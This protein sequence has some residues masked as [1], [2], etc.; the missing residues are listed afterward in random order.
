LA[1]PIIRQMAEICFLVDDKVK[2]KVRV[3]IRDK[4]LERKAMEIPPKKPKTTGSNNSKN[5]GKK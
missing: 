4:Q 5:S 1:P 3:H 2:E